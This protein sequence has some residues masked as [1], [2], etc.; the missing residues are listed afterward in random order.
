M[1]WLLGLTISLLTLLLGVNLWA[2]MYLWR[3]QLLL[4]AM[5]TQ[6]DL[7]ETPAS[8]VAPLP[9]PGSTW[10]ASDAEMAAQ[11]RR[12]AQE[13]RQRAQV[14]SQKSRRSLSKPTA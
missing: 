7:R 1:T 8:V 14:G 2:A 3:V 5:Q 9:D 13:S 4:H 11:E 12:M 10:T 6:L